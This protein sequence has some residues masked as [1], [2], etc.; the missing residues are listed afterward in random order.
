MINEDGE[1]GLGQHL[2]VAVG[3]PA[4]DKGTAAGAGPDVHGLT[5]AVVEGLLET[6]GSDQFPAPGTRL[7]RRSRSHARGESP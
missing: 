2:D 3:V 4:S 6:R 5:G 1:M 7:A